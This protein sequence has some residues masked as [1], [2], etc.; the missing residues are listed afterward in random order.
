MNKGTFLLTGERLQVGDYLVSPSGNC[1]VILDSD[2]RFCLWKGPGPERRGEGLWASFLGAGQQGDY[3]AKMQ[4]D[5]HFCV[6]KKVPGSADVFE[7]GTG[8]WVGGKGKYF[9]AVEDSMN[10]TVNKGEPNAAVG[11]LWGRRICGCSPITCI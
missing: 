7:W 9:A 2:G 10:F 1:H 8:V 4:D 6:Y 11:L 3:Y 5:G